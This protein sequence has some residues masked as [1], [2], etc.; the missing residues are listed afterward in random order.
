MTDTYLKQILTLYTSV[1]NG[2]DPV[3][4][5]SA[6]HRKSSEGNIYE[7]LHDNLN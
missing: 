7:Q 3:L 5:I 6:F 2:I 4:D 1:I